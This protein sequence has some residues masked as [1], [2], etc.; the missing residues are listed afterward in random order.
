M[1][2][3]EKHMKKFTK[4][5]VASLAGLAVA[6]AASAAA[7]APAANASG[8]HHVVTEI[9]WGGAYCVQAWTG[10][11][12]S[13]ETICGGRAVYDEYRSSGT[14][15]IDPEM[16][17]ADWLSCSISIDGR[18]IFSDYATRGNGHEVTCA[19]DV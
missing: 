4:R 15:G 13:L 10:L 2:T 9:N 6:G 1:N 3:R 18:H 14:V 7:L 19:Y 8:T 11:T 12:G 5:A 16:S 17:G